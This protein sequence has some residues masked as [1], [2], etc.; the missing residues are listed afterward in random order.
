MLERAAGN[1][2]IN[3]G[4]PEEISDG[5]KATIELGLKQLDNGGGV[6]YEEAIN[7]LKWFPV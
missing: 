4:W 5:E 7:R 3:G 2:G 6:P 1:T